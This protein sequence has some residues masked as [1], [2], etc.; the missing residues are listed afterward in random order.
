MLTA[1]NPNRRMVLDAIPTSMARPTRAKAKRRT[2]GGLLDDC[3]KPCRVSIGVVFAREKES[4]P[5][6]NKFLQ[7]YYDASGISPRTA[8]IQAVSSTPA[9]VQLTD[10]MQAAASAC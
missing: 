7:G 4:I 2:G 6:W 9:A 5:Y 10:A 1:N 8:S 3:G